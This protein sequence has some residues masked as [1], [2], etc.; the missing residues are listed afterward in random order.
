[1]KAL[2]LGL[3]FLFFGCDSLDTKSKT[4]FCYVYEHADKK[5]KV[6]ELVDT[7]PGSRY[8]LPK[9]WKK[10]ISSMAFP[11]PG[12]WC[13]FLGYK[14]TQDTETVDMEGQ[15]WV[16]TGDGNY[17]TMNLHPH[18]FRYIK[19]GSDPKDP[20]CTQEGAWNDV[21]VNYEFRKSSAVPPKCAK[22][23]NK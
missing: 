4:A 15:L 6:L 23:L 11:H 2:F 8:R 3:L 16:W 1:M 14:R 22:V 13:V 7:T 20:N 9:D 19:P 17:N 21:I 5:G 12:V 10:Q 18:E